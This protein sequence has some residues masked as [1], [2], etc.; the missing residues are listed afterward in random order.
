MSLRTPT[1]IT[2]DVC[3]GALTPVD[4]SELTSVTC[5]CILK[6]V[7]INS[8]SESYEIANSWKAE[9]FST[10]HL[11][12][13]TSVDPQ[14][15]LV[16]VLMV[17][18]LCYTQSKWTDDVT[19]AAWDSWALQAPITLP[20]RTAVRLLYTLQYLLFGRCVCYDLTVS[21]SLN[22]DRCYLFSFFSRLCSLLIQCCQFTQSHAAAHRWCLA[23][24][25][26]ILN[27][28]SWTK[29]NE[30]VHSVIT[31]VTCNCTLLCG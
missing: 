12:Q 18:L 13:L 19:A 9:S 3:S 30:K 1:L 20:K 22:C 16:L 31:F 24:F 17:H 26:H 10:L 23:I 29:G 15:V 11:E 5:Y 27:F 4:L 6:Y 28:R 7:G 2:A 25:R 8:I 14:M 21:A